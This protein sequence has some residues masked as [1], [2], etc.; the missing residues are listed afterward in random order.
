MALRLLERAWRF[1]TIDNARSPKQNVHYTL[2]FRSRL[3]N[4]RIQIGETPCIAI[5]RSDCLQN[6]MALFVIKNEADEDV[7]IVEVVLSQL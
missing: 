7:A 4:F 3:C 6:Q 5:F 1:Q 2:E